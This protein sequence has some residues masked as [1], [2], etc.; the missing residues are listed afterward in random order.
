MKLNKEQIRKIIDVCDNAVKLHSLELG[1]RPPKLYHFTD[2][3]GMIGIIKEKNLWATYAHGLNDATE[4]LYGVNV[5]KEHINE[6]LNPSGLIEINRIPGSLGTGIQVELLKSVLIDLSQ[7]PKGFSTVDSFVISFCRDMNKSMHWLHYG[8]QG[9]GVALGFEFPSYNI[10]GFELSPVNYDKADLEE[11]IDDI[12][13]AIEKFFVG[14][15]MVENKFQ[16][17]SQAIPVEF[18][19]KE[20]VDEVG[21][22]IAD[23]I[24]FHA[25]R[26]KDKYF[27]DE[28]EWRLIKYDIDISGNDS[29]KNGIRYRSSNDRIIPYEILDF[30]NA[31]FPLREII[32]GFSSPMNGDDP[33]LNLLV[34]HKIIIK[35][36][37]VPI[38]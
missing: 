28:E 17:E 14:N 1:A 35:K 32:L 9:K 36:S 23:Y 33:A 19:R 20:L 24:R 10:G 18:N 29:E 34:G 6:R 7:P 38:R 22:L 8:H 27:Q 4:I 12:I 15:N 26:F 16:S 13:T 11:H 21:P 5:A 30:R 3:S 2:I 31:E 25:V 37:K